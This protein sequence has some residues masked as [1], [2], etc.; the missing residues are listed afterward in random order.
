[1]GADGFFKSSV[2]LSHTEVFHDNNR[3]S[4]SPHPPKNKYP[5]QYD[6]LSPLYSG[7]AHTHTNTRTL[8]SQYEFRTTF[9]IFFDSTV[10]LIRGPGWISDNRKNMAG[11]GKYFLSGLYINELQAKNSNITACD[12]P[13]KPIPHS[14]PDCERRNIWP[15]A[16]PQR[17]PTMQINGN[18]VDRRQKKQRENQ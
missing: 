11:S 5:A 10:V 12:V 14:R 17:D 9:H 2:W 7:C 3:I 15:M 6:C 16:P 13:N 18:V 8:T 4:S 1:M